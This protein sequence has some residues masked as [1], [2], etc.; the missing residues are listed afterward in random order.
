M[1]IFNFCFPFYNSINIYSNFDNFNDE[2]IFVLI[3]DLNYTRWESLYINSN[4]KNIFELLKN[5]YNISECLIE[6]NS[7]YYF[8]DSNNLND[9]L[10]NIFNDNFGTIYVHNKNNNYTLK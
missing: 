4:I 9:K 2:I 7:F 1:N 10:I 8:Q 3:I 6:L 5:K